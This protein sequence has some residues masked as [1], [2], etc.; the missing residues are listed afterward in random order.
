MNKIIVTDPPT[1]PAPEE[2]TAP[3]VSG[4]AWILAKT[5]SLW[6]NAV[7]AAGAWA[8]RSPAFRRAV[9]LAGIEGDVV[10]VASPHEGSVFLVDG[11]SE[12]PVTLDQLRRVLRAAPDAATQRLTKHLHGL[13]LR[14]GVD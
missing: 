4:M 13:G 2:T 11:G 7:E 1:E 14:L 9:R 6:G 12:L 5:V 3:P 8:G 10:L